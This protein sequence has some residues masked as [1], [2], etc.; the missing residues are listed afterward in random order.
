MPY[1]GRQP[2]IFEKLVT[3]ANTVLNIAN[4]V[5]SW[6]NQGTLQEGRELEGI[7]NRLKIA[8][9]IAE[10]TGQPVSTEGIASK[11]AKQ[12]MPW[13]VSTP[14]V[15]AG[16]VN[17]EFQAKPPETTEV[18]QPVPLDTRIQDP[19]AGKQVQVTPLSVA[20]GREQQAKSIAETIAPAG[21][22]M[23][24]MP[25]GTNVAVLGRGGQVTTK[26]IPGKIQHFYT[27]PKPEA[28]NILYD[29]ELNP[30]ANLGSG[31]AFFQPKKDETP[32]EKI[33]RQKTLEDYKQGNREKLQRLRESDYS[34]F[35]DS[36]VK[37]NP[38][39]SEEDVRKKW[40]LRTEAD[41]ERWATDRAA[42]ELN[43]NRDFQAGINPDTKQDFGPGEKET[44]IR[45]KA[46]SYMQTRETLKGNKNTK[47]GQPQSA[48]Y[49]AIGTAPDGHTVYQDA[50]GNKFVSK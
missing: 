23:P 35:R 49:K 42:N 9:D 25:Q 18:T 48:G 13:P 11:L 28:T 22:P 6:R 26:N 38:G 2:G 37:E 47:Q 3:G 14:E 43:R 4:A 36:I 46:K 32:E 27:E 24:I 7:A 40:S 20:A 15:Q 31:R 44:Y 16:M 10:T 5:Q 17:K 12:G 1:Y 33:Q 19:M 8:R 41:I 39:I 29:R 34:K 21:K 45:D 50:Q 30:V